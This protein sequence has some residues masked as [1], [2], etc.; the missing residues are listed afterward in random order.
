[1]LKL[2][3]IIV[4][5]AI[6]CGVVTLIVSNKGN[7]KERAAEA[8]GAAIGGAAMTAGCMFQLIMSALPVIL[9]LLLIKWLFF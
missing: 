2:L 6:V 8:A 7:P 3:G 1:M 9:G 5:V 4:V